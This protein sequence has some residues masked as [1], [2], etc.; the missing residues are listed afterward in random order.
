M[1]ALISNRVA[2]DASDCGTGKTVTAAF[3]AKQMNM[4]VGVIC[5]KAVIPSWKHW[6]KEAG[7]EPLFV[8]NYEKLRTGKKYGKWVA[9]KWQWE[10]PSSS[11]LIF[12][13]VHK[14]K[15][16]TSQN[17]KILGASKADHTVLMLSATAAQNPL[18]MRWTGDL[19]GIHTGTNYWGWLKTMKVAKAPWGGFQ[20]YGGKEGL[21][22]IHAHI[23]PKKGVRTRVQ[24]LGDAFPQNN[25]MSEVFD[26]DDRIGKLYG[27]MEAELAALAQ[28]KSND[29]DP[30]E[31]RT[32]LLRLRQE[33]ELLRVPVLT[34]MANEHVE[35]G[36][37]VVIFTNFMQTCRTLMERLKAPAI[38]GEQS[39]EE[40]QEAIDKFQANKEH[41][42]IVQIQAGGVGLSLHDL[43][44]RPRV[45]L[46]CPTYSAI[47]LKQALG[48]IARTGSKSHCI[49]YLVYAANS[50][51]E[52][53][54]RKTKSK[55]R[56]I[57]LLN[58]GDLLVT[59]P[60]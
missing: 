45:S 6:L 33:V 25:V 51:E 1:D 60:S 54:A 30:S 28:A 9:K 16:Y 23:F 10:L 21:L 46:V 18:D 44:G 47:D 20:Y 41:V 53:V 26:I 37:S 19:L 7:V 36:C 43:H 39:A 24:D 38:H 55:I 50:V 57:D 4:P 3:V 48:R 52:Q 32:R 34:E 5:P 17:G 11:L 35:A 59:L 31:P 2:L 27:Q 15:G 49:Q 13:E 29:F 8:I 58:D 42:I 56:E 12:D 22:A 40:R 14:C